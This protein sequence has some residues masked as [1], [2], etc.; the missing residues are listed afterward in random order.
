MLLKFNTYFCLGSWS[1]GQTTKI[2]SSN[3]RIFSISSFFALHFPSFFI[4][5]LQSSGMNAKLPPVAYIKAIDVWIGGQSAAGVVRPKTLTAFQSNSLFAACLTFIFGALL[6]FA[7]VTYIAN[8]SSQGRST[9][10]GPPL[11]KDP[12]LIRFLFRIFDARTRSSS[13]DDGVA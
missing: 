6:E 5:I 3:S 9:P 10:R 4:R 2:C 13:E 8:R 1:N 11:F 7:W 12:L